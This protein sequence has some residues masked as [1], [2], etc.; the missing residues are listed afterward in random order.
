MDL[1][2]GPAHRRKSHLIGMENHLI[3]TIKMESSPKNH[4]YSSNPEIPSIHHQQKPPM[5]FWC[6]K[7]NPSMDWILGGCNGVITVAGCPRKC[8]K[9]LLQ[10]IHLI[11]QAIHGVGHLSICPPRI[12]LRSWGNTWKLTRTVEAQKSQTNNHHGMYKSRRK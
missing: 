2:S 11:C 8:R 5:I 4:P 7:K 12:G 9:F 10:C 1:T 3:S 6:G